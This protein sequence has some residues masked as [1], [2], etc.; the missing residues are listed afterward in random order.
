MWFDAARCK[1]E[2]EALA[3]Y[4]R[5]YNKQLD[6]YKATPVHDHAIHAADALRTLGIA[7]RVAWPKPQFSPMARRPAPATG[8]LGWR[9]ERTS[10]PLLHGPVSRQP[11]LIGSG[12]TDI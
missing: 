4:R 11:I 6:E 2:L 9:A 1:A 12:G 8:T 3:R 10:R 5:A 7:H